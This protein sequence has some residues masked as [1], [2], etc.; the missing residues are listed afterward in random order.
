VPISLASAASL[1]TAAAVAVPFAL[2]F[3]A[4]TLA[5]RVVILKVRG[6]GDTRA[7]TAT[8]TAA[9][10]FAAGSSA[11]LGLIVAAGL[12]PAAVLVAATPG[13]L[14]AAVVATHPPQPN[15]LR[16]LGWTLIAVSVVT[17]SLLVATA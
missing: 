12:L 9:L 4:S 6:G 3:V 16:A 2:L 15:R 14:T 11:A 5:V 8:R 13:L 17:A 10:L 1:E 7:M